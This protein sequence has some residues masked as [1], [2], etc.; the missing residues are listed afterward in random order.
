MDIITVLK[1]LAF[2]L[3]Y[4]T[5]RRLKDL[6]ATGYT[7]FNALDDVF[8]NFYGLGVL[9]RDKAVFEA[10]SIKHIKKILDAAKSTFST[11]IVEVAIFDGKYDTLKVHNYV[12]QAASKTFFDTLDNFINR[13]D[14]G[15]SDDLLK[16]IMGV[17][18]IMFIEGQLSDTTLTESQRQCLWRL[19]EYEQ[20]ELLKL[21]EAR[22]E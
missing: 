9:Y 16:S 22:H 15:I 6:K 1:F 12:L 21:R 17:C 19:F 18:A 10:Q 13:D 20:K 8:Y 11:D 2:D 7:L 4:V 14:E 3:F 5:Q